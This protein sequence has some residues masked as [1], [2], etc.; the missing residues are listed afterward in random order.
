MLNLHLDQSVR[1]IPMN[2]TVRVQVTQK[3]RGIGGKAQKGAEI[4]PSATR[5]QFPVLFPPQ[6]FSASLRV[7]QRIPRFFWR[8]PKCDQFVH[9]YWSV[10]PVSLYFSGSTRR[11]ITALRSQCLRLTNRPFLKFQ[12]PKKLSRSY[13][14]LDKPIAR[15]F[16]ESPFIWLSH[17]VFKESKRL[18]RKVI[19]GIGL[20]IKRRTARIHNS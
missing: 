5:S 7:F 1:P 3:N 15:H 17:C 4:I 20:A 19:C 12:L 8:S 14:F 11:P 13:E 2:E 10:R 18:C 9:W 6:A 16:A